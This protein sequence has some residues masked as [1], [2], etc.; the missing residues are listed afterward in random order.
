MYYLSYAW[1]LNFAIVYD[2]KFSRLPTIERGEQILR[3]SEYTNKHMKHHVSRKRQPLRRTIIYTFM[4]FC[5]VVIVTTMMLLVLGYSIN[6]DEGR[7]EQGGLLQLASEPNGARV[8]ID[9]HKIGSNTDT[10]QTVSAGVHQVEFDLDRYHPWSKSVSLRAG[11]VIW[12]NYARLIPRDLTPITVQTFDSVSSMSISPK[13]SYILVHPKVNAT[14]FQLVDVRA[15]D[16]KTTKIQLPA[17]IVTAST[18]GSELLKVVGWSDNENL[19]LLRH[20]FSNKVEWILLNR[21]KP[22]ESLNLNKTFAINPSKVVFAGKSDRLLFVQIGDKVQRINMDNNSIS[23]P[24]AENV[25]DFSAYDGTTVVYTSL[26]NSLGVRIAGYSQTDFAKQQIIRTYDNTDKPFL[27]AMSKYF[28]K[29]NVAVIRNNQLIVDRGSLPTPSSS[30]DLKRIFAKDIPAGIKA[31]TM[32]SNGRFVVLEYTDKFAVYDIELDVFHQTEWNY[33]VKKYQPVQ[34]LDDYI[35]WSDNGDH[36]RVYDFDG[37]N[38]H[39][40]MEVT[41]GFSATLAGGGKYIYGL[42]RTD[43]GFELR[44]VRI[45]L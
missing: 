40:V 20:D 41:K 5:V 38:Q 6:Q 10:K 28:N 44:Q 23:D 22:S 30:A 37:A 2:A 9:G 29:Q 32:S 15:D 36:L 14:S 34:W 35:V 19:A 43:S 3:K 12:L 13:R 39:D 1:R 42:L 26:P 21:E 24:I 31:L 33:Q 7:I 18:S 25:D 8:S 17:G 11:Q 27:V 16:V 45:I 4:T